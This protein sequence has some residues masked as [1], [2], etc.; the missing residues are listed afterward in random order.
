MAQ[1]KDQI[2][3]IQELIEQGYPAE[4]IAGYTGCPIAYI[5]GFIDGM[6]YNEDIYEGS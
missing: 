5:R 2:I 4:Y 3:T 1:V 6:L